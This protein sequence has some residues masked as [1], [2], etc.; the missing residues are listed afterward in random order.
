MHLSETTITPTTLQPRLLYGLPIT[1][2][3]NADRSIADHEFCKRVFS[4]PS[5][6]Q[7]NHVTFEQKVNGIAKIALL[8]LP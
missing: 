8:L 4:K 1:G 5:P 3:N 7:L 2:R 6:K